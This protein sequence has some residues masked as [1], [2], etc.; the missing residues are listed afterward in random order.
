MR[1]S[2]AWCGCWWHC[3]TRLWLMFRHLH[4][5]FV[6]LI[7]FMTALATFA[8]FGTFRS[9]LMRIVI[10]LGV[11]HFHRPS[12]IFHCLHRLVFIVRYTWL[13][14]WI[15][16][17]PCINISIHPQVVWGLMLIEVVAKVAVF[18][19][20]SIGHFPT[21]MGLFVLRIHLE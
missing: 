19:I 10:I 16:I 7:L 8:R 9:L 3:G 13:S 5:W 11:P 21:M 2:V 1:R 15:R 20:S 4:W 6:P 17:I 12:L 14:P 18:M